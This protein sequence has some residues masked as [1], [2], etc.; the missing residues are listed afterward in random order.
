MRK[1]KVCL[2]GIG[3]VG[4]EML[5]VL[6]RRNFPAESI[7][8][9]A[10]SEREEI[11]DGDTY[12]VRKAEPAVFDD[13]DFALFAGTEGASGASQT[14][15]WEAVERGCVVIDNGK[16]FRMDPRVPLVVPEVNA[17]AL[18]DHQGFIANPNCST[19]IALTALGPLHR[20]LGLKRMIACT[21]QAVSGSG[22]AAIAE[23]DQQLRDW[24]AGREM[25]AAVYP[26]PIGLNVIPK[27][28]GGDSEP[29]VTSEELKMKK[30][31][32][33]ILG[34][35][36][37]GIATTCVR[38]PVF[39]GHTEAIHAEF[40]QPCTVEQARAIFAEAPGLR[41]VDDLD[42]DIFPT[43]REC[44]GREEVLVGRVRRDH[45]FE[46][47]LSF[48]VAGDN[49]W[50]GAALNTIQIAEKLI[51]MDLMRVPRG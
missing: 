24:A 36:S 31:S 35:D 20:A 9:L 38:V 3:A 51:E 11:I 37:I 18:R 4:T 45:S 27:I 8:I 12:Q 23:L 15:G 42:Q 1:Y 33:K 47:G 25:K 50:K 28:G 22:G 14:L 30:E 16:D 6:K 7:T 46:N 10:R 40:K 26:V 19:I 34:D 43:P 5:R 21:Y 32:H 44:D 41:L 2:I 13:M 49:L 39:N 48:V 29:G 17:E